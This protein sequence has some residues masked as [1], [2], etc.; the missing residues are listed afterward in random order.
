M[1]GDDQPHWLPCAS[2]SNKATRATDNTAVPT[3]STR[4]PARFPAS[5]TTTTVAASETA[6][7]T[8]VIQNS[9]W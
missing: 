6:P 4:P 7:A 1:R 3:T 8:A 9:T 5:G 2:G